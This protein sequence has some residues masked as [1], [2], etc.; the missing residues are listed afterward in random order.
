MKDTVFPKDI[1]QCWPPGGGAVLLITFMTQS[2]HREVANTLQ[3]AN[4]PFIV[5][6]IQSLAIIQCPLNK[7]HVFKNYCSKSLFTVCPTI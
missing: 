7:G 5:Y 6:R 3:H 1:D 4:A 2:I